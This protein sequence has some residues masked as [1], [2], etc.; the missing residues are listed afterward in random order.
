[1]T[2]KQVIQETRPIPKGPGGTSFIVHTRRSSVY[3]YIALMPL[4][5][6]LA[7]C[8]TISGTI[9]AP[10]Q[11]DPEEMGN[12]WAGAAERDITP[13]PGYPMGGHSIA[14]RISRGY[15]LRLYARS[16]FLQ[17][18]FGKRLALV[19]VDLWSMPAGLGDRVADMLSDDPD[20]SVR[21]KCSLGRDGL[22]IAATHTHQ[23]PGNFSSSPMYNMFASPEPGF[24]PDLFDFLADGITKSIKEACKKENRKKAG[25][26]FSSGRLNRIPFARNRSF[27]AF[28]ADEEHAEILKENSDLPIG[29]ITP[30][31]PFPDSYRAIDPTLKILRIKSMDPPQDDIAV[32]GFIAVHPTSLTHDAE[33]Y[34]ADLFG[35]AAIGVER[36]L[37]AKN[38]SAKPV[39]ALFNGAEGDISPTWN[40]QDRRDTLRLGE[41]LANGIWKLLDSEADKEQELPGII[42][43]Q[44]ARPQLAEN[45]VAKSECAAKKPLPG[46]AMLGGAEDG[47]TFFYYL[48]CRE[49]ITEKNSE[50]SNAQ[51]DKKPA[52]TCLP[53]PMPQPLTRIVAEIAS[54]PKDIPIGVYSIGNVILATLPGE[55]TTVL[56]RRIA[57]H[58]GNTMATKR[59]NVLLIGPANEYISYFTTPQEYEIQAYEGA[60]MLYGKYS[61]EVVRKELGLLA[62]NL[63]NG[64]TDSKGPMSYEY[65]MGPVA[66]FGPETIKRSETFPYQGLAS[67]VLDLDSGIPAFND[68]PAFCWDDASK[69]LRDF[70]SVSEVDF[71][72]TPEVSI[73][74][75][76]MDGQWNP[77][78][79]NSDHGNVAENDEGLNFVTVVVAHNDKTDRWCTFWMPPKDLMEQTKSFRFSVRMLIGEKVL[80]PECIIEEGRVNRE[81]LFD[82]RLVPETPK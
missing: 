18:P 59:D 73:Y 7:G 25:I 6:I 63:K 78:I 47:R 55:F 9:S 41:E 20:P 44:F 68:Y 75:R 19:S 34:N 8:A 5:I 49:G 64:L 39:V 16:I 23:S 50:A 61:G 54:A 30:E 51:G 80:S 60:S 43:H 24:D 35:V 27:E 10:I 66:H 17:D 22:I 69:N 1:M 12:L 4:L 48:G 3:F 31:Y 29:N 42:N 28:L 82:P 72:T 81:C 14:G 11:P 40:A 38:L 21:K 57:Q 56:G 70:K 2:E 67:V 71:R 45:C 65:Y 46:V 37:R 26:F 32:A 76:N 52:L 13:P 74:E 33:V 36:R 79:V 77:L 62:G 15:W 58:I 53:I